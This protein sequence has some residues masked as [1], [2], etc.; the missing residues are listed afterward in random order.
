MSFVKFESSPNEEVA[1]CFTLPLKRF[2]SDRGHRI[3]KFRAEQSGREFIA[4]FFEDRIEGGQDVQITF[5]ITAIICMWAAMLV[6]ERKPAFP[7]Y[8]FE[9]EEMDLPYEKLVGEWERMLNIYLT[10]R[11]EQIQTVSRL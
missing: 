9:K 3:Q 6:Y 7:I 8:M 10:R 1:K 2:L 4:H 5:G 11:M